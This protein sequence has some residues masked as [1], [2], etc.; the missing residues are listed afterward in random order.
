MLLNPHHIVT[1]S[2]SIKGIQRTLTTITINNYEGLKVI[3][4]SQTHLSWIRS[5]MV[6]IIFHTCTIN[7]MITVWKHGFSPIKYYSMIYVYRNM[8]EGVL[9][10]WPQIC[11]WTYVIATRVAYLVIIT[12]CYI[13]TRDCWKK[14]YAQNHGLRIKTMVFV[15]E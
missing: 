11:I 2:K 6:P 1:W 9:N 15:H 8:Y 12:H 5:L 3:N 4:S 7:F 13:I 10:I 14:Q